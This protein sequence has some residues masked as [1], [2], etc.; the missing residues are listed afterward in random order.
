MVQLDSAATDWTLGHLTPEMEAATP[1]QSFNMR[2]TGYKL[3]LLVCYIIIIFCNLTT[4]NHLSYVDVKSSEV[5]TLIYNRTEAEHAHSQ[6]KHMSQSDRKHKNNS[7]DLDGITTKEARVEIPRKKY[8]YYEP[9]PGTKNLWTIFDIRRGTRE[10]KK[11]V[12]GVR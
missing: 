3:T 10:N 6:F 2:I 7:Y 8:L 9:I 5:E 11:E 12:I 1:S 4:I